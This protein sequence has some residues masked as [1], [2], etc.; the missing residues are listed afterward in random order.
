MR[1]D[2][3]PGRQ[4]SHPRRRP[5]RPERRR[6]LP[7]R[8]QGP[9]RR[10]REACEQ[11]RCRPQRA[12]APRRP[13]RPPRERATSATTA[14][15][16]PRGPAAIWFPAPT[17]PAP[18]LRASRPATAA[19]SSGPSTRPSET[20]GSAMLP[21][22]RRRRPRRAGRGR[23]ARRQSRAPRRQQARAPRRRC[24][25]GGAGGT[26][27]PP[28]RASNAS[29]TLS[30][31]ARSPS[32]VRKTSSRDE[33]PC[34][35]RNAPGSPRS[36]TTPRWS[37]TISW[38][39]VPAKCRSWV[40]S[41]T[42]QPRAAS[43]AT[44]SLRTTIASGIERRGR[45]VDEDQRWRQRECRNRA[46][47]PPQA[48][49]ERPEPLAAPAVEAERRH[50]HLRPSG[51]PLAGAPEGVDE[52]DELH[53]AEL[54]EARR[55]VRNEHRRGTRGARPGRASGDGDRSGIDGEQT[56]G[57][58]E[59]RRLAGAVRADEPDDGTGAHVEVDAVEGGKP[60]E[61]LADAPREERCRR[62]GGRT[63]R[64]RPPARQ[65]ASGCDRQ[66]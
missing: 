57:R 11:A 27:P 1:A 23:T 2:A 34:R 56:G 7:Q 59:Q 19:A 65:R 43:V 62:T 9:R 26:A 30:R 35:A 61:A 14:T 41:R 15:T 37:N 18:R 32:A 51:R 4:R 20:P 8:A 6:G 54:V 13:R 36:I 45:L 10:R 3:A 28:H 53:H 64:S 38:H 12:T 48:A 17:A 16:A 24:R 39:A 5:R 31:S 60:A 33:A 29:L 58:V 50:E 42:P 47:L 25:A 55:L 21:P 22:P 46:R 63:A 52:R 40:A 66:P 44:A 49:G